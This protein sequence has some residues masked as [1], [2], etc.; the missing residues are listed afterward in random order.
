MRHN[1]LFEGAYAPQ[2]RRML[3]NGVAQEDV[4]VYWSADLLGTAATANRVVTDAL[5]FLGLDAQRLK[6]SGAMP[7]KRSA[8]SGDETGQARGGTG[9]TGAA[10]NSTAGGEVGPGR[11]HQAAYDA[12]VTTQTYLFLRPFDEQL[13]GLLGAA[14]PWLSRTNTRAHVERLHGDVGALERDVPPWSYLGRDL[15]AAI[16]PPG[17]GG[18]A[19]AVGSVVVVTRVNNED[20]HLKDWIPHYLDEGVDRIILIDDLSDPPVRSTDPR[21]T[22][23]RANLFNYEGSLLLLT[24]VGQH[25]RALKYTWA[26][27][28]DVDEYITTRKSPGRTLAQELDESF[29]NADVV[30]V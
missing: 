3:A 13:T 7:P 16:P 1:C 19:K 5:G 6:A 9:P 10:S 23:L 24:K 21:V 20:Y 22:V 18:G 17:S 15:D 8:G 12:S 30:M 29:G 2:L 25:C 11:A 26:M 4:R 14:A 28:I 27:F